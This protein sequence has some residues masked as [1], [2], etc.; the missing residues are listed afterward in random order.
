MRCLVTVIGAAALVATCSASA[1]DILIRPGAAIGKLRLGMTEAEARKAYAYPYVERE[2]RPFGRERVEISFGLSGYSAVLYGLRGRTRIV[3]VSTLSARE[4]TPAGTGVGTTEP[5]LLAVHGKQ[6]A[7]DAPHY[8]DYEG[9]TYVGTVRSCR[10]RAR[11][12]ETIFV[13][14]MVTGPRP[15]IS[16]P[17]HRWES[18]K[19]RV[20]RVV[21]QVVPQPRL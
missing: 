21:V 5:R 9:V 12:V 1:A 11:G 2:A 4:R 7:C 15:N 14:E 13:N 6:L 20:V 19:A 3:Q 17:V 8:Y 16:Y 18:D 10:L